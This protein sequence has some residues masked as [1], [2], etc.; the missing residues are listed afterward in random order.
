MNAPVAHRPAPDHAT[1][2]TPRLTLRPLSMADTGAMHAIFTDAD[3]MKYWSHPPL[4]RIEETR[5]SME[6]ALLDDDTT[7][8][9]AVT[10][11]GQECLGWV[12]LFGVQD[13]VGW[14]GYILAPAARGRGLAEEAVTAALNYG[15]GAW[16]LHRIA[17]N[18]D[19]RNHRSAGLLLRL[20]FTW[21]GH[22]RQD[23]RYAGEFI[24]TGIF[25]ILAADWQQRRENPPAPLP[26]LR[27]G[28]AVLRPLKAGDADALHAAFGDA[29]SMRYMPHAHYTEIGQTR[30][31]ILSM[32]SGARGGWHWAITTDGGTAL[33]WALLLK[34]TPA[35][36]SLGYM[37][38]PAARGK[39]LARAATAAMLHHAFTVLRKNRVEAEIDPRNHASAAVLEANGFLREGIRRQGYARSHGELVDNCLY[40]ILA[41][42]WTAANGGENP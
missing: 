35:Q 6:K 36:V 9:W 38:V 33:G 10:T 26:V 21:E 28:P 30:D 19:P 3:S 42:E 7:R 4:T 22:Q 14:I 2:L 1:L 12:S 11:D 8:T 34:E 39:G 25:A 13:R 31:K 27:H 29:D 23:F 18:I 24:D 40:G 37:L 5:D 16:N 17:A 20:G 32:A 41:S 15:F